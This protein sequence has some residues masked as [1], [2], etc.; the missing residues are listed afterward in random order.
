LAKI[1]EILYSTAEGFEVSVSAYIYANGPRD[2]K[3][4]A[5]LTSS[6]P[7]KASR[8]NWPTKKRRLSRSIN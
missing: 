2:S 6:C 5:M 3:Y 1:Q 7:K 8:V 4:G